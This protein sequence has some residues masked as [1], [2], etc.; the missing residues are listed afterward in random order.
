MKNVVLKFMAVVF[1]G[2]ASLLAIGVLGFMVYMTATRLGEANLV[3]LILLD[4]GLVIISFVIFMV[5][6]G[7]YEF[8]KSFIEL[9]DEVKGIEEEIKDPNGPRP[10]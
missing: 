10:S 8:M 5:G 3:R 4:I 1:M 2:I 9:K 6:L 7:A